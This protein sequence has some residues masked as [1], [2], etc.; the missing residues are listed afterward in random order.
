MALKGCLAKQHGFEM[1]TSGFLYNFLT[2][3]I[4]S[5]IMSLPTNPEG[6]DDTVYSKK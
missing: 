4:L 2:C 5:V 1:T 6:A 3:L